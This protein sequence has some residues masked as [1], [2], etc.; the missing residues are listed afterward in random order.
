MQS[1]IKIGYDMPEVEVISKHGH[2]V[3]Y[4]DD[5]Y[6]FSAYEVVYNLETELEFHHF[7]SDIEE[8]E[9]WIVE[10]LSERSKQKKPH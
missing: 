7:F 8:A 10:T 4:P 2:Y 5:D 1:V 3:L 9:Y 6:G